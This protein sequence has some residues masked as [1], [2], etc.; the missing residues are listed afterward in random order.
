MEQIKFFSVSKFVNFMK[1]KYSNLTGLIVYF[2]AAN[3]F[4]NKFG[5]LC[6]KPVMLKLQLNK[7]KDEYM[8]HQLILETFEAQPIISFNEGK[9][10]WL[11]KDKS[12]L[13]YLAI[14]IDEKEFN[15]HKYFPSE[16]LMCSKQKNID[17]IRKNEVKIS[18][19]QNEIVEDEINP[20]AL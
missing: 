9:K 12:K 13:L 8:K 14:D 19:I 6:I 18:F 17:L 15:G 2:E 20:D 11:E 16:M 1:T 7:I 3:M 10:H 5:K 4:K